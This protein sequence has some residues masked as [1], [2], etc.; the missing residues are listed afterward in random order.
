MNLVEIGIE[1]LLCRSNLNLKHFVG[2]VIEVVAT[3]DSANLDIPFYWTYCALLRKS[4]AW[5]LY[6]HYHNVLDSQ[7]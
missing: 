6:D 5:S 3:P 2:S 7:V 4:L 1:M